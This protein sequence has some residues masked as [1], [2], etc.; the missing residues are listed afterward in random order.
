MDRYRP[1]LSWVYRLCWWSHRT[2]HLCLGSSLESNKRESH[3]LRAIRSLILQ[4]LS[5]SD[6]H[7]PAIYHLSPQHF[8]RIIFFLRSMHEC[9]PVMHS[10]CRHRSQASRVPARD[11]LPSQFLN[12]YSDDVLCSLLYL[13]YPQHPAFT[14]AVVLLL[15][16]F[17]SKRV[18][19]T[20][21]TVNEMKDVHAAMRVLKADENRCVL[22]SVVVSLH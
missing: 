16:I 3:I 20:I 6:P 14:A 1:R 17:R 13:S 18:G 11:F 9:G 12:L 19:L 4:L 10:Y 5:A 22:L 15:N 7:S 21:D 2:H 8:S